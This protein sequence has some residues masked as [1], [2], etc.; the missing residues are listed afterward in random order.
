MIELLKYDLHIHSINS[1][2]AYGSFY[3]IVAEARKKKMKMIAITDH[4]PS[5]VGTLGNIHFH[6]GKRM[7]KF[8]DIRVLWGVELNVIDGKGTVDLKDWELEMLDV[9]L[10]G[11]HQSTPYK[12]L[13]RVKNTEALLRALE[14][15]YVNILTHPLNHQFDCDKVKIIEKALDRDVLLE[16]NMSYLVKKGEEQ[17]DEYKMMVDLVR[18]RGKKFILNTDA[19][20]I[21]EIGD[22]S[23]LKKFKDRIGLS[24]D[25]ILKSELEDMFR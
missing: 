10:L 16:L 4:G 2:H 12:D 1:G 22:D 9:V 25:L 13:G 19:H 7:P 6:L 23:I 5:M 11:F 18:K 24:D 21:H 14:N 8:D 3:D 17:L 20:F 15:P